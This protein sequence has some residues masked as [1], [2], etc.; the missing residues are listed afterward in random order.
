MQTG[1]G[2]CQNPTLSFLLASNTIADA[3]LIYDNISNRAP[4]VQE[5]LLKKAQMNVL[6]VAITNMTVIGRLDGMSIF[7]HLCQSLLH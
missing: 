4:N 3:H 6:S 2:Q 7:V 1:R 5:C